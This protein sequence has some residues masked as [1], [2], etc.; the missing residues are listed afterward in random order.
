MVASVRTGPSGGESGGHRT[1]GA[2]SLGVGMGR[3][4]GLGEG[5]GSGPLQ[6]TATKCWTK[7]RNNKRHTLKFLKSQ[8]GPEE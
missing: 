1:A 3:A 8:E 4:K 6:W 2:S 7:T 5:T